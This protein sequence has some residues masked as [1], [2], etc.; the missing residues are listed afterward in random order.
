VCRCPWR[1]RS[2]P[3]AHRGQRRGGRY[4]RKVG[5]LVA[6]LGG[7]SAPPLGRASCH[8]K[9]DRGRGGLFL[10]KYVLVLTEPFSQ[11]TGRG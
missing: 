3:P 5:R 6:G 2:S 9:S 1:R 11:E 4:G 7:G 10:L 8:C